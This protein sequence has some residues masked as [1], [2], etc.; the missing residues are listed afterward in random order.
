[1]KKS[2]QSIVHI[3]VDWLVV[4]LPQTKRAE[5]EYSY[6]FIVHPR[7]AN[8]V[9]RKY[10][11][12]KFVPLFLLHRALVYIWPVTLSKITGLVSV[13]SGREIN[14]WVIS[15][16]PT[17]KQLIT[18]RELALKHIKRALI[19]AKKKGAKIV[20]L[21]GLISSLTKGGLDLINLVDINLTTGHAYTA[22]NVTRNF[23]ELVRYFGPHKGGIKIA[24][25]GAT[26]SIGSTSAQILVRAGYSDILLIDL[27][28]KKH[29]FDG[30]MKKISRINNKIKPK[31]SYKIED[32]NTAN[33]IITA[34]N[35]PE[36]LIRNHFV[37]SGSVIIDDAQP[38]DVADEVLTREDVLTVEAGVVHTPE[39]NSHFNFGLKNKHDNFCCMAELLLLA[40]EE[41]NEHYVINK[42]TLNMVDNISS[43]GQKH[44]FTLGQFQ[45]RKGIISVD[46]LEKMKHIIQSPNDRI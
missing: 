1:M 18:D 13:K 17:A 24:I 14:G 26:G 27:E 16:L 32:I 41:W 46:M 28:R 39:I 38:S 33:Y 21:G 44:G 23:F 19:L 10:P 2:L 42:A 7:D 36:A 3:V 25:V 9:Y 4:L 40:S 30:L 12:L 8:D 43:M 34:T 37:Q 11:F 6:A 15:V 22:Y 29:L 5:K 20:G 35:A 45:N 31:I